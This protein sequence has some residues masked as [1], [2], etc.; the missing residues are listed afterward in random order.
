MTKVNLY[1]ENKD[2][3][4]K[5]YQ[6]DEFVTNLDRA[7]MLIFKRVNPFYLNSKYKIELTNSWSDGVLVSEIH[8]IFEKNLEL[9]REFL[10]KELLV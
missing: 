8:V 2:R 6:I 1:L 5:T 9:N 4:L 7:R 10:L 3:G